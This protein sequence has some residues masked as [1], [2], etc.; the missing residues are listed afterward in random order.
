MITIGLNILLTINIGLATLSDTCSEFC[1]AKVFG[2]IS[3]KISTII[4]III[5]L[6]ATPL[7]PIRLIAKTVAKED[8]AIFTILFPT[9]IDANKLLGLSVN[10]LTLLAP[11]MFSS[12]ICL[13]L[14]LLID[15]NAVSDA[16]KKLDSIINII[17][18]IICIYIIELKSTPPL[19]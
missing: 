18:P 16:E 7:L 15:I 12:T 9:K 8:D 6:I 4:V 13:T 3:P 17:N 1:E 5:V 2:V 14:I 11:F 19:P 10:S